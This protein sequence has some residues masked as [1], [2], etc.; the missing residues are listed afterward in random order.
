MMTTWQLRKKFDLKTPRFRDTYA[1]IERVDKVYAP[2]MVSKRLQEALPF[3]SKDKIITQGLKQK[4]QK[5]ERSLL[6]PLA[7]DQEKQA[8]YLVQRLKLIKKEKDQKQSSKMAE[9]IQRRAAWETGMK[10]G[11]TE[12]VKKLRKQRFVK[13]GLKEKR[14]AEAD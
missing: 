8:V 4:I 9:K 7:S 1:P 13:Q 3:R 14:R 11:L 2:V 12:Q 10:K 5:E 6:K